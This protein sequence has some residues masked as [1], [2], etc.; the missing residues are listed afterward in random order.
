M[1][2]S[3]EYI[4]WYFVNFAIRAALTA[5]MKNVEFVWLSLN[6]QGIVRHTNGELVGTE[7]KWKQRRREK[8]EKKGTECGKKGRIGRKRREKGENKGR[9]EK[10]KEMKRRKEET[11]E[12]E[13][14]MGIVRRK[15]RYRGA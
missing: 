5:K 7:W 13:E 10:E 9:K 14:E 1:L 6:S 2:R 8:E 3:K 11:E 12:T 15:E 4:A